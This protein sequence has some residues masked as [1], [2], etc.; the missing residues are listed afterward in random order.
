MRYSKRVTVADS[1]MSFPEH[2]GSGGNGYLFEVRQSSEILFRDS[3]ARGGRHNF[4]QNWG[5]GASGIV[6][7]RVHSLE[8][9]M[10]GSV[11]FP[12]FE[13]PTASEFHH[14][15]A[16]A[17]LI[18]ASVIDDAWKAENRRKYSSGAGHSVT[19]SVFWN[20]TGGGWLTS[21][22]AGWGYV[23]GTAAGM[24]VKTSLTASAGKYTEPEDWVEGEGAATVLE[25]PS[26]Y[27]D[28]RA[29]RLAAAAE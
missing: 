23:I 2:R 8:S 16:M 9:N 12:F 11:D 7:L 10:L 4:I 27:D 17:C 28:Q 1:A 6:W 14:S 21:R 22:Q 13:V 19:Q 3:V 18:D 24:S 20:V 15:L 26:L 5:F 25:P 29:R